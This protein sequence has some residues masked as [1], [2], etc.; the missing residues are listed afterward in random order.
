[1]DSNLFKINAKKILDLCT[2]SGAIAIS[3]AKYLPQSEITAIDISK[4]ALKIANKNAIV[5]EVEN[6]IKLINSDMFAK[7]QDEKFD[8][9]VS[10]LPFKE[11]VL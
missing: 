6:Q 2:G 5:N 10:N 7:L 8:I 9:I 4:E 3:L 1:M 11:V